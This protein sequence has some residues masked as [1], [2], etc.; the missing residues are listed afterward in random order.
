MT[1]FLLAN[2]GTRD[3]QLDAVEDLPPELVNPRSGQLLPRRAGA[4]L[5]EHFDR[6]AERLRMP[7]LDKALRF[8][9]LP[10]AELRVVL[11]ATNQPEEVAAQ[12]RDQDTLPF[13]EVMR[14]AL[15]R[16]YQKQ[17]M[18]KK[19]I[20][21]RPTGDNP[22]DYDLMLD[23]YRRRL[24]EIARDADGPV[25]LLIA[26]GTPQM[27]T[28]L[29]FAGTEIFGPRAQPLYVSPDQDRAY[30]LDVARQLYVQALRS[31]IAVLLEAY[32]Y[33]SARELLD[34]NREYFE[35]DRADL[36]AATLRYAIARRNL[37][38][39]TAARAFD[40]A[41]PRTRRLR[42]VIQSFVRE[43]EDQREAALLRE[44]I[45]LA[46]IAA[47]PRVEDWNE[48]LSRLHRFAEGCLQLMAERLGV[49]WSDPQERSS[50]ARAW[51]EEQ[52]PLLAELGLAAA[53]A[54]ADPAS[55]SDAR[56]ADRKNLR[57]IVG[58]LAARAGQ[59]AL[60]RALTA[61]EVVERPLPLRNRVV[62][63]FR[64]LSREEVEGKA[65]T[66]VEELL[67]AMRRAYQETF[68]VEAPEAS[69]YDTLNRLCL[70]ALKGDL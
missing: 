66:R 51:W 11:F 16:R 52:R 38:L 45:F 1:T 22:A 37:D 59:E 63:S 13:A 67:A 35:P 61:L 14:E 60:Q 55:E 65:G 9:G 23:F 49:R 3:V 34:L 57:R 19:Q 2:I 47:H 41:L 32:T 5:L 6:Y 50:F 33:A 26:G 58:A 21:I 15:F 31:S 36:L 8:L 43:V 69:P 54:P 29:L 42:P 39:A 17:G 56:Q 53:T 20:V 27:N 68:G 24:P 25:Y 40:T 18:A 64:P 46:Q 12:Y 10:P 62:H 28:M 7:M 48:F 70:D 4:Y 30:P 44:T